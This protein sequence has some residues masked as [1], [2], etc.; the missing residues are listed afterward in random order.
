MGPFFCGVY[1]RRENVG[2][3]TAVCTPLTM[4]EHEY[5]TDGIGLTT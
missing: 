4:L 3:A 5:S 2:I 1:A